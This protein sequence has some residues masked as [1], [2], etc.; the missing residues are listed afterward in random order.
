[1][2]AVTVIVTAG[3]GGGKHLGGPSTTGAIA[4]ST[5]ATRGTAVACK[6]NALDA[7]FGQSSYVNH[8][9]NQ[10]VILSNHG[11]GTCSLDGYPD[12]LSP[13]VT[14][15][16]IDNSP[17]PRSVSIL[18]GQDASF[19]LTWP[20]NQPQ[21]VTL[22]SVSIGFPDN[23]GSLVLSPLSNGTFKLC[24]QPGFP[25]GFGVSAFISGVYQLPA[26]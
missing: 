8:S 21:C 2:T 22:T 26:G 13:G 1:V 6:A 5:T 12:V 25:Y 16:N 3:C 15:S 24:T 19:I 18:P 4:S 10:V 17:Q 7:S 14:L 20:G 23:G 11:A 9:A